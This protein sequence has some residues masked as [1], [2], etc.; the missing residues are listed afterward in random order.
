M[1]LKDI[2]IK[3]MSDLGVDQEEVA[4]RS[5]VS[6]A[7]IS[8]MVIGKTKNKKHKISGSNCKSYSG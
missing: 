1:N 4:R 5:G 6:Q 8:K 2:L 7:A 3:R